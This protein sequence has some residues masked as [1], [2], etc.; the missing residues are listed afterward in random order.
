MRTF[1][2]ILLAAGSLALAASA[3]DDP[4]AERQERMMATAHA[5]WTATARA[6]P[7]ATARAG[8]T[9]TAVVE[10]KRT[11]VELAALQAADDY[12]KSAIDHLDRAA[13]AARAGD[14]AS[15]LAYGRMACQDLDTL[16]AALEP[17]PRTVTELALA[18]SYCHQ[19]MSQL[20][21]P[22]P[23][24]HLAMDAVGDHLDRATAA[25]KA[26]AER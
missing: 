19:A 1:A 21:D 23:G 13:E 7:T 20:L 22:G 16:A 10:L 4:E 6:A 15:A 25:L 17:F 24:F 3:C 8:A 12:G 5:V 11:I 14:L 9:A 2:L 26:E 18:A